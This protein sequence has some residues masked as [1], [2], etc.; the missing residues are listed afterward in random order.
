MNFY[1]RYINLLFFAIALIC[2]NDYK[3]AKTVVKE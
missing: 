1:E 2:E 3:A